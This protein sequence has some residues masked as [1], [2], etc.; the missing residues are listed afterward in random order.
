MKKRSSK[1]SSDSKTSCRTIM[2]APVT[3]STSVHPA[4]RLVGARFRRVSGLPGATRVSQD[5]RPPNAVLRS[6][7]RRADACTRPS[8]SRTSPP[9]MAAFGCEARQAARV[10]TI[11]ARSSTSGLRMTSNGAAARRAARL[12]PAANPRFSDRGSYVTRGW[13]SGQFAPSNGIGVVIDDDHV[14]IG[15]MGLDRRETSIDLVVGVKP[16]D[17]DR[18]VHASPFP[19]I[20]VRDFSG[21]DRSRA[22]RRRSTAG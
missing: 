10:W 5:V 13:A 1:P 16:D 19:V 17:Q 3:Q 12:M 8:A 14:D 11:G 21:D 6:G 7:K 4:S 2:N 18:D 9:T 20:N 15:L 22:T